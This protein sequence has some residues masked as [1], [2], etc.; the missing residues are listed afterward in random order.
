MS[1]CFYDA[2]DKPAIVFPLNSSL[3]SVQETEVL[4]SVS[5]PLWHHVLAEVSSHVW[6]IVKAQKSFVVGFTAEPKADL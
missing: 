5:G 2:T 4:T 3:R 6:C 1:H